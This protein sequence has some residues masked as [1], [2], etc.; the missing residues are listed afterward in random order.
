MCTGEDKTVEVSKTA[1]STAVQDKLQ[2]WQALFAIF[3]YTL[4]QF[5]IGL[6]NTVI[7]LGMILTALGYVMRSTYQHKQAVK[8]VV[9]PWLVEQLLKIVSEYLA[10]QLPTPPEEPP[11]EPIEPVIDKEKTIEALQAKIAL[12][13]AS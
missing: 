9:A 1:V 3:T 12:L 7:L 11:E 13:E 2:P 10:P 6:T 4:T 5:D 8:E